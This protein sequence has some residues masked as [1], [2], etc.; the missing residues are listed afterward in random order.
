MIKI[1]GYKNVSRD[2]ENDKHEKIHYDGYRFYYVTD[3]EKNVRG[4][5]TELRG[6][7]SL[8]VSAKY[9]H[10]ITGYDNPDA[11]INK[12]Y[13]APTFY[14]SYGKLKLAPLEEIKDSKTA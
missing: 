8:N 3:E 9:L 6:M 13:R 14:S 10:D 11:V 5:S 1:V 12:I 2:F 4:F 7:S